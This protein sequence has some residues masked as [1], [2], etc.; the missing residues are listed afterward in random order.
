MNLSYFVWKTFVMIVLYSQLDVAEVLSAQS[1][2]WLRGQSSVLLVDDDRQLRLCNRT[3]AST[4]PSAIHLL[5]QSGDTSFGARRYSLSP[6]L[7]APDSYF[8]TRRLPSANLRRARPNHA[9]RWSVV[10]LFV[11]IVSPAVKLNC[12]RNDTLQKLTV[13]LS[14]IIP[15]LMTRFASRPLRLRARGSVV[16]R[17]FDIDSP[18]GRW[19]STSPVNPR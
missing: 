3:P 19:R 8:T 12:S 9:G 17:V 16:T 13:F 14:G 7:D 4:I 1:A 15:T 11:F 2:V 5:A 6:C 18:P 10:E